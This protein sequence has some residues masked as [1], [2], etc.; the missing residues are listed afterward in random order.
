LLQFGI[1]ILLTWFDC[2]YIFQSIDGE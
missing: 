1:D 2:F